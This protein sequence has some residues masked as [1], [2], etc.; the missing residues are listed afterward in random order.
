MPDLY[1]DSM[2]VKGT[3]QTGDITEALE[4]A[5]E[6]AKDALRSEFVAW[7]LDAIEGK[8]GGFVG[9]K[10]L[11]VTIVAARGALEEGK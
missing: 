4:N 3:S 1:K 8:Y 10:D 9:A 2:K 5:V 11:E 6:N 7:R